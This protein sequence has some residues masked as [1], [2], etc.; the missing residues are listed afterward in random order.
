MGAETTGRKLGIG[1]RLF[2]KA[3]RQGA[4]AAAASSRPP[5]ANSSTPRQSSSRPA[6]FPSPTIQQA[7]SKAGGFANGA[8]GF[9]N[10]AAG[11]ANGAAGF[12]N[13]AAGFANGV[14]R[15]GAA[16]LGPMA[17]TGGVLWLEITGLFF[18]LFALFFAQ[19][20][21]KFRQ[22]YARGPEHAHFLVYAALAILFSVFTATQFYKARRKE[23]R[24][25]ARM[26]KAV[27]QAP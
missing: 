11:F 13:G 1:V 25:R 10:G 27:R 19:N 23:K 3:A 4:A 14:K 20:V 9:A 21:Y 12:A 17:H 26:A 8:A 15:F 2:A 24:N 22:D 5:V 18:G 16:M 7:K 6:A